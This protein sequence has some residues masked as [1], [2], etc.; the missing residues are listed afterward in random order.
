MARTGTDAVLAALTPYPNSNRVP[1]ALV[2][3]LLP[4]LADA[5]AVRAW[6]PPTPE[7]V[8]AEPAALL[9]AVGFTMQPQILAARR[10]A[11][12]AYLAK[13]LTPHTWRYFTRHAADRARPA[14]RHPG[15]A[16]VPAAQPGGAP[17]RAADGMAAP[18]RQLRGLS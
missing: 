6:T 13:R 14:G 18:R 5:E 8:R 17:G 15:A 11:A 10:P 2:D 16:G 4:D 12:E 9:T 7:R 1:L 3:A